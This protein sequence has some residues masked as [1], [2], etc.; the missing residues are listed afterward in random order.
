VP[1]YGFIGLEEDVLV[2]E[3]GIEWLSKPQTE[4]MVIKV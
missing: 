3:S 2:T 4:I 1:E